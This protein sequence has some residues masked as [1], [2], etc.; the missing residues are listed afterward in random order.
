MTDRF[1]GKRLRLMCVL[2]WAAGC[3]DGGTATTGTPEGTS[4]GVAGSTT[5]PTTGVPDPTTGFV[6]PT[7]TTAED[8]TTGGMAG[9]TMTVEPTTTGATTGDE[10]FCGDGMIDAGEACDDG[11]NN[12]P[13]QP[14]NAD[15]CGQRL[16]RRR[17]RPRRGV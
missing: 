10:P 2:A 6:D 7:T 8:T 17:P 5:T 16:R 3:G 12:G 15:V 14:C 9:E 1:D 4:T 11:A 13:G